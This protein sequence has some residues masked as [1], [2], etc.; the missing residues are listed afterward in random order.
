MY[1]ISSA[2]DDSDVLL[3]DVYRENGGKKIF[4]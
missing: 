3:F 1:T 2:S 4:V